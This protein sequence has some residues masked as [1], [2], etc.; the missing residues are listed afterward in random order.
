MKIYSYDMLSTCVSL[1]GVRPEVALAANAAALL[2]LA[3]A[4]SSQS[5]ASTQAHRTLAPASAEET[6]C[7]SSADSWASNLLSCG[8]A[9]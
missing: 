9:R 2:V 1:A 4:A 8:E 5:S 6:N 7:P 3:P